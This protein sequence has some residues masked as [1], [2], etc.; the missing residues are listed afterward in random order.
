MVR[1]TVL[2]SSRGKKLYAVRDKAGKFKD[3]QQ[4]SRAHAMDIKRKSKAEMAAGSKKAKKEAAK[5]STARKTARKSAVRK[6][7]SK[8]TRKTAARK[9]VRRSARKT[10]R[11]PSKHG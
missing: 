9:T 2:Y 3:I 5:K 8:T 6:T 11:K 1:R 4:Y 7:A 10:A